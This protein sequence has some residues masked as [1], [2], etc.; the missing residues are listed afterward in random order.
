MHFQWTTSHFQWTTPL[1]SSL[2]SSEGLLP[3]G[4]PGRCTIYFQQSLRDRD[5]L[6][7][8]E[9]FRDEFDEAMIET[10]NVIMGIWK[11]R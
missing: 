9:Q 10:D 2:I 11:L 1:N 3:F 7:S 8:G 4:L 5:E 6:R